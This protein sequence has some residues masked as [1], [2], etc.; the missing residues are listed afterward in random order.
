MIVDL[1]GFVPV[2][3]LWLCVLSACVQLNQQEYDH[4]HLESGSCGIVDSLLTN[5]N[6]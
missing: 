1:D 5:K 3:A 6:D 4:E 2:C